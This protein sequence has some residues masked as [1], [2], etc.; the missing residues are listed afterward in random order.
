MKSMK[1]LKK[2]RMIDLFPLSYTGFGA[3]IRGSLDG[4]LNRLSFRESSGTYQSGYA[5]KRTTNLKEVY[6]VYDHLL[7]NTATQ[8]WNEIKNLIM[9]HCREVDALNAGNPD[10]PAA[11]RAKFRQISYARSIRSKA[12]EIE[13]LQ[14]HLSKK[15]NRRAERYRKQI[16]SYYFGTCSV[17]YDLDVEAAVRAEFQDVSFEWSAG[18]YLERIKQAGQ[19]ADRLLNS[20]YV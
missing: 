10:E 6:Y 2:D 3:R 18:P 16:S 11:R 9:Q 20:E 12:S 1:N 17:Y 13:N 8:T 5:V 19:K 4:R 7:F 15:L 14:S